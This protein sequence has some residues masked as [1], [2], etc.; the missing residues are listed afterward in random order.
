MIYDL[1]S[2]S[3]WVGNRFSLFCSSQV[4]FNPGARCLRHFSWCAEFLMKWKT[5]GRALYAMMQMILPATP[6]VLQSSQREHVNEEEKKNVQTH[7]WYQTPKA[8]YKIHWTWASQWIYSL[9]LKWGCEGFLSCVFASLQVNTAM[10]EAK[11]VE[12]CDELV[13]IIR[14]RKQVIAVKI[15]E[16]KVKYYIQLNFFKRLLSAVWNIQIQVQSQ[17]WHWL[18]FF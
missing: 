13:E 6:K 5:I 10:H 18:I 3:W 11:L 17:M 2:D 12:E 14:Q 15:K 1:P 9:T 7:F 8:K 4:I 16:S